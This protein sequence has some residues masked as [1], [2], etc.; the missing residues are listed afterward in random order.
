MLQL[1]TFQLP[2]EEKAANE[3]MAKQRPSGDL[4]IINDRL[5]IF[6]EDG[7]FTP[8]HEIDELQKMLIANRMAKQQQVI[9]RQVAKREL[10]DLNPVK[11]KGKYD[12]VD[13][14]IR[15]L[16]KGID[17]QDIKAEI[18]QR[19]IDDLRKQ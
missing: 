5:F 12:E 10:A 16:E 4:N 13:T 3:F 18:A 6:F 2:K 7:V 19:R 11:N 17:L 9:G 15:Q 14:V 8:E 1:K